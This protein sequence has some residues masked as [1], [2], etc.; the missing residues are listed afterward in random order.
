[1]R[2]FGTAVVAVALAAF[3]LGFALAP[4]MTPG[5]TKFL[6]TRLDVASEAGL[7]RAVAADLA[8]DV[9]SFVADP[10]DTELPAMVAGRE[11]F[12][13]SAVSHLADVAAV[14]SAA[15][16][17]TGLLAGAL[18]VWLVVCISRRSFGAISRGLRAGSLVTAGFVVLALVAGTLDF[19]WLFTRFHGLFFESGTWTF[20]QGALL[21]QLFPEAFWA[22]SGAVWGALVL[23][24]AG[25]YRLA[26]GVIDRQAAA[27]SGKSDAATPRDA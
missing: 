25:A 11:G 21:I 17:A 27:R 9:R 15:R 24:I 13:E 18:G 16:L 8:E 3:A 19:E 6:T 1:M 26:A 5:Y 2:R 23:L 12:D 14:I 20:P 10:V 4:L 7:P 22:T